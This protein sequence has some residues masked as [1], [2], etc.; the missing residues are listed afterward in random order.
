MGDNSGKEPE[1]LGTGFSEA[2][3]GDSNWELNT[4]SFVM[5]EDEGYK[6]STYV[7]PEDEGYKNSAYAMPEERYAGSE[8]QP[9]GPDMNDAKTESRQNKQ[10]QEKTK[11]A[12]EICALVFGVLGIVCFMCFGLFGLIG[13]VLSII[14][15]V[16]GRASG[17]SIAGLICSGIGVVC[18]L[19]LVFFFL[20]NETYTTKIFGTMNGTEEPAVNSETA[21]SDGTDESDILTEIHQED[22]DNA[23]Y[24]VDFYLN[25]DT[26]YSKVNLCGKDIKFPC[27]Y[28]DIKDYISLEDYSK[29]EMAEGIDAGESE[30]CAVALEDSQNT[31]HIGLLNPYSKKLK[32]VDEAIVIYISEADYNGDSYEN[33]HFEIANQLKL[34]S[35]LDDVKKLAQLDE[36]CYYSNDEDYEYFSFSLNPIESAKYN[37]SVFVSKE[38]G[39]VYSIEVSFYAY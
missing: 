35:S 11:S 32:N 5:P 31:F 19:L 2:N 25:T 20:R 14:C 38:T 22:Y 23:I 30:W 10:S 12:L 9:A 26:E 24:D 6:N 28:G 16:K 34:G 36:N 4:P 39:K 21:I 8:F 33:A 13:I 37:F 15:F 17:F 29:E 1:G 27:K 18:F 7:I 3:E